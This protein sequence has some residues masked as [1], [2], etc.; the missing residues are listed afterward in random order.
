MTPTRIVKVWCARP[1]RFM[2]YH[3]ALPN[4]PCLD[5]RQHL[6]AKHEH[7]A[8]IKIWAKA[9]GL[10]RDVDLLLMQNTLEGTLA[11][12]PGVRDF[13]SLSFEAIAAYYY[14]I[15]STEYPTLCAVEINAD[16]VEGA[17]AEWEVE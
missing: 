9:Q 10:A 12:F 6:G 3:P 2:H 7:Q 14:G 15:L 13:A 1:L 11:R 4:H 8:T 17:Y 16:G 5:H